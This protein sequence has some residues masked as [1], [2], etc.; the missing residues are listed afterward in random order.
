MRS[1]IHTFCPEE[2][3]WTRRYRDFSTAV[4]GLVT[5]LQC[6]LETELATRLSAPWGAEIPDPT[7]SAASSWGI[8]TES[9]SR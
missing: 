8:K 7:A 1:A 6:L 2:S 3:T 4:L 9:P 5:H